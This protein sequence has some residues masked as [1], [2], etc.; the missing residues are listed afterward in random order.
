M[1]FNFWAV[2]KKSDIYSNG[3]KQMKNCVEQ[4][5]WANEFWADDHDPLITTTYAKHITIK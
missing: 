1:I 5:F 3:V 2:D 4:I